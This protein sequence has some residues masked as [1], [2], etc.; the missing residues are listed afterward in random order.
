MDHIASQGRTFAFASTRRG[1]FSSQH[2]AQMPPIPPSPCHLP[3]QISHS[4]KFETPTTRVTK[5]HIRTPIQIPI[6]AFSIQPLAF[7]RLVRLLGRFLL[8]LARRSR[9]RPVVVIRAVA[10]QGL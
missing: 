9:L 3:R 7:W 1:Y 10:P 2:R 8:P 6:L 4:E 5:S